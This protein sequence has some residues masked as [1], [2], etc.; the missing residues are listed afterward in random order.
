LHI[1]RFGDAD[2]KSFVTTIHGSHYITVE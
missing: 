2:R 1:D